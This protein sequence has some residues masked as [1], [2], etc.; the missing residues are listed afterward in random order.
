VTWAFLPGF[1]ATHH[2]L[3]VVGSRAVKSGIEVVAN[4]TAAHRLASV[5]GESLWTIAGYYTAVM[6]Q[7]GGRWVVSSLVF[8]CTWG[9]GNRGLVREAQ[10]RAAAQAPPQATPE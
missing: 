1:D 2:Q 8:T 3:S 5:T 7:A 6:T 9:S 4:G 10:A